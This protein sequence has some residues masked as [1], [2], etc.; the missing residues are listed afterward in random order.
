MTDPE[1]T[2]LTRIA[3]ALERIAA[4]LEPSKDRDDRSFHDLVTD[5]AELLTDDSTEGALAG[6]H[7]CASDFNE[8]VSRRGI[9]GTP[10]C[11]SLEDI[12]TAV[13]TQL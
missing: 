4:A 13:K 12:A 7:A 3:E 8:A 6:I 10:I 5:V 1:L 11:D 9:P 2:I